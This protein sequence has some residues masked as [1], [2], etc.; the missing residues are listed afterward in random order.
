MSIRTKL[1][2]AARDL[3]RD[4]LPPGE[5]ALRLADRLVRTA[6]L[7]PRFT[8]G[9]RLVFELTTPPPPFRGLRDLVVRRAGPADADALGTVDGT[10]FALVRER[11]DRGDHAWVGQLGDR[12]LAKTWF[13]RG[14]AP[15]DESYVVGVSWALTPTTFW[16]YNGAATPEARA[17]GVFVKLFA[18]ALR[19]LFEAHG[20]QRVIGW[21]R[22]TN[23]PSIALH[24]R[25]GWKRLGAL[26]TV[27]LPAVKWLR[28]EGVG[29]PRQWLVP[30]SRPLALSIPP[31]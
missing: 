12:V 10:P 24:E 3:V 21:I 8:V 6:H 25:M 18:H 13:Q 17:T 26:V 22:D 7:D 16:S 9:R 31:T 30:R 19:E 23:Q 11:L 20:A 1:E 5:R 28:W 29:G 27:A 4:D 14:P 15:F 2:N